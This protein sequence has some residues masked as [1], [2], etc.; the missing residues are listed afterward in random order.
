MY[1]GTGTK[2]LNLMVYK[3]VFYTDIDG[4]IYITST[5][6]LT[7]NNW[8]H[9]VVTYGS[10]KK[11]RIYKNGTLIG[12]SIYSRN[13][14]GGVGNLLFGAYNSAAYPFNGT[15]D[16]V[17]IYNYALDASDVKKL[18]NK[19]VPKPITNQTNQTNQTGSLFVT[20]TP[21]GAGIYV[22]GPLKGL[23]PY[24]VS[25]L[26]IGNHNIQVSKSGYNIYTTTKYIYAGSNFL[27]A[28]LIP[29][30]NQTNQT[31]QTVKLSPSVEQK[32]SI[33]RWLKRILFLDG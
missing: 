10:D 8:Q 33:F 20:S 21:S 14:S 28:T 17:Q 11:L 19:F 5:H 27:D 12:T 18:Y 26:S 31:N 30:T 22:D 15:I 32:F 1:K 24:T 7:I 13:F 6:P 2:E 9:V 29:I 23:T 3:N 4:T 16:E 25:N